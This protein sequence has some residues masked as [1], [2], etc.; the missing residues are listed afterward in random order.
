M[1]YSFRSGHVKKRIMRNPELWIGRRIPSDIDDDRWWDYGTCDDCGRFYHLDGMHALLWP[2]S[3]ADWLLQKA[4][5]VEEAMSFCPDC[6]A[7]IQE[8]ADEID[9][10][11]RVRHGYEKS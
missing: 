8:D 7:Q 6:L 2:M 5:G 3:E 4:V 11:W 10:E 1:N 9:P